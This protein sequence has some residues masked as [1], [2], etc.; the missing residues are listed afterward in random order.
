MLLKNG[1]APGV[2]QH[3]AEHDEA[4]HQLAESARRNAEHAPE[5][6]K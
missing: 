3:R 6:A 2:L 1:A 4:D 5:L